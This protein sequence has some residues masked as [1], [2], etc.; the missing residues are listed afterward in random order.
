[1]PERRRRSAAAP[2]TGVPSAGCSPFDVEFVPVAARRLITVGPADPVWTGARASCPPGAIVRLVAPAAASAEAVD[3]ARLAFEAAGAARCRVAG[4][5][6]RSA[7]VAP[8]PARRP[9]LAGPRQ[10][11]M[12]M[13]R[14]A[15]T[16]DR[17][18]LVALLDA[19]LAAEGI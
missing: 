3:G 10:V 1:M 9:G 13:A 5:Q 4:R 2:N 11:V 12:S 14:E 16:R 7:V 19:S 17:D 8:A 15:R 6:A 18:A